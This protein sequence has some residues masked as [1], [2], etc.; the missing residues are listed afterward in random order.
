M[1][2][3]ES[4]RGASGCR[5]D[6]HQIG[7]IWKAKVRT[8]TK[9]ERRTKPLGT[10]NWPLRTA[11]V[12]LLLASFA[13][14]QE[15]GGA[16]FLA[17]QEVRVADLPART[18][19]SKNRPAVLAAALE[20]VLHD[21]AVCCEKDSAL[22]DAIEYA[23]LSDPLSLKDFGAKL[24]GRHLLSNGRP[25]LVNADYLSRTAISADTIVRTLLDHRALVMEWNSHIY[26]LYG[27]LFNEVRN[28]SGL[29][30]FTVIKLYL[31]D[32]RFSDNRREVVFNRETDD[33]GKV[34]GLLSVT[35]T[36]PPSPWK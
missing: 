25:V 19:A 20:T 28:Y 18:A 6:N 8:N 33:L 16:V 30:E 11:L 24:Q 27:A 31:L 32:P 15:S 22:A 21:R 9:G 7:L 35:V 3:S 2:N 17:N 26:V 13:H 36:F 14:G 34:Q 4:S 23:A 10:G 29:R 12:L 1:M 5:K